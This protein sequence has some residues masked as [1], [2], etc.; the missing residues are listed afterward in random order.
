MFWS[1]ATPLVMLGVYTFVFGV[2][3]RSR[4]PNQPEGDSL[5]GFAIV[6]FAG[7]TVF[8]I[9]SET[10][11]RAPSMI[12][13]NPGYV[14]KVIFPL[15]I[16][17]FSVLGAALFNA[18]ICVLLLVIIEMVM[19]GNVPWTIVFIPVVVMPIV[20]LS[21]GIAWILASLGVYLRD[22]GNVVGVAL[23]VLFFATPIFYPISIV[24]ESVRWLLYLNPLTHLVE[25]FRG[26]CLFG[27]IPDP[28]VLSVTLACGVT[29]AWLGYLF[30]NAT[31]S[32]FA[33][34]I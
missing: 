19:H 17:P 9:F 25:M 2:V 20:L 28:M 30:F 1:L 32:G 5:L 34:V 12:L 29:T 27:V 33:D 21:L 6:L 31:R 14:K 22:V 3:F 4:W 7:T 11:A 10:I 18:I 24:P 23:Q 15:E 13:T 26:I 16:L 8:N